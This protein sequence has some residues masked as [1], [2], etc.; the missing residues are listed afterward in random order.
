MF[1]MFGSQAR[2]H[3]RG[4]WAEADE[5]RRRAEERTARL[6]GELAGAGE[7]AG[8]IETEL[9]EARD[10][11][12][13]AE[14]RVR[15]AE[16]RLELVATQNAELLELL[17]RTRGGRA[18]GDRE[19]R[20]LR[21]RLEAEEARARELER[22][23]QEPEARP[24]RLDER[25][26]LTV[27]VNDERATLREAVAAEV[28]RQLT[29]ILGL[30]LA[31]RHADTEP[32]DSQDM[33]RR[34]ATHA[35]KL[36]RLVGQM[37]DLER[38]ADGTFEPR[39][40]R[41]DL[42]SL[43]RR[44][45]EESQDLIEREVHLE[46]D[47]VGISVDPQLA[48]QI[49]DALLANAGKRTSPGN[50]V[51]VRVIRQERGALLTVEDT[52]LEVQARFRGAM[53]APLR[54]GAG[55]DRPRDEIG[56]SVLAKLAEVQGGEAWVEERSGGR[57]SFRVYLPDATASRPERP[58]ALVPGKDASDQASPAEPSPNGNSPTV[59]PGEL[60]DVEALR[61]LLTS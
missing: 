37:L 17:E 31:L 47:H 23:I 51:W 59:D 32:S 4:P 36:D 45:V 56:L 40:R 11:A 14:R 58:L 61:E 43:V 5:R 57:A 2:P 41:T 12:E 6:E 19:T 28:R 29:S 8:G 1:G 18:D 42:E 13:E 26:H 44:V 35:R 15:T 7:R 16:E 22:Q 39:R 10:R 9:T 25:P 27:V 20:E 53:L 38:I 24:G 54:D 48:E 33:I 21:E 60:P 50:T 49:V 34:L 30:T 46:A 3:R 55:A 52:G